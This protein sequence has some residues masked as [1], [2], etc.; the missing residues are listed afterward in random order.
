MGFVLVS[1]A[2][3]F[4]YAQDRTISG[5][6]TSTEDGTTLPGVNVVLK[7]TS[8][9][10]VTDVDGNYKLT[11][12]SEGGVLVFS[13][14]G[15]TSQEVEI[16]ARSVIDV[17]MAA[18]VTQLSEVV[19]TALGLEKNPREL[20]YAVS[21]VKAEDLVVAR[22][23]NVISALNGKVTGVTIQ[24]SSGNLG[25]S[26]NII[27]RGITSLSGNNAPL[28]VVDG[29]PINNQQT[30]TGS[31]ITG[32]RDFSNGAVAL[33]PDDIESINV[34]K[35]GAAS[36][37]YGSRAAAGV[38]V[39]TTKKG[40]AGQGGKPQ[41][42]VNSSVRFDRLFTR[43]DYQFEYSGGSFAKYDSSLRTTAFGERII[44]QEVS[45]AI[46]GERVPLQAY[47]DNVDE[48]FDT[49]VSLINNV[50][51]SDANE[52]MDY[53]LSLTSLNQ[54]GILPNATLDRLTGNFGAGV[55]HANWIKSR[56][57]IQYTRETSQGTGVAGANDPNIFNL[58]NFVPTTDFRDFRP[59]IDE[60]G[61]QINTV[62]N[63]DN[64]PF[65]V[66]FENRNEREQD[67]FIGSYELTITPIENLNVVSRIGLDNW[68]DE[69]FITNRVGT[70]G[71]ATGTF[72]V[73]IL[74]RRQL[75]IDIVST[76]YKKINEDISLNFLGAFNY[77]RRVFERDRLFAESLS[78]PELFS[79]GNALT[80]TPT[81]DE[82]ERKLFGVA[83][84]A[85]ISYKDWAT[86]TLTARNDWSSTLPLENNSY[87]YP[88]ASLAFVFTDAFQISNN[89]LSFGKFRASYAQVGNDT[90]PYQLD[91]RFF[92][93]T[94]ATGQYSLN[95]NFPFDGRLGFAKTNT[96]P[97][98]TLIPEDQITYEF[99][100]ELQFFN[101]RLGLDVTYFFSENTNQILN[102]SIPPSTGF[103]Q[104]TVNVGSID[105]EGIEISIDA[106]PVEVGNFRWNTIVN[107]SHVESTVTE[108]APGL[109]RFLQ[110]SGFNSVQVVAVPGREFQLFGIP[111][112]RE[113]TTGRIVI[114]EETGLRVPGAAK[115]YG[116][117]MPDFT[118][119]FV[120]NF[121]YKG[122]SLSAT[123]DWRQGGL[124]RSASVEALWDGGLTEETL[125]NRE[126]TFID[127]AGVI[128][129]SDGTVREN[130][131]PV[132]SAEDFWAN[133]SANSVSESTVFDATFVKLREVGFSY[134]LPKSV[135]DKI[136]FSGVQV[137]VEGRNLA[138][139]YSKVPH[140][141]P[142]A[143]L[144]GPGQAGV[145]FGVERASVPSTRSFG[146]N[147][148]LTF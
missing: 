1:F 138:L 18:D 136:P 147:V 105:N 125:R 120:N 100:T 19:V 48:Y 26:S 112:E 3:S 84:Q 41:I 72:D 140:I 113:P 44:G 34:L 143:N 115:N 24:Q 43:P 88:S 39:V 30:A 8:T 15:L 87:F 68:V 77:N 37:L 70:R 108:L 66:Q 137:G 83:G 57:N 50:S 122:F 110:A 76:Y 141:D 111:Y 45:K 42:T 92:P 116:S 33:N 135:I 103:A 12:P 55:K 90:N 31:R 124:L 11:V 27:V 78:I 101:G 74:Q 95:L 123:I 86:L 14:I 52:R 54:E 67:R 107:F 69:R 134:T 56:F 114:D 119:G 71:R 121:T 62:N 13:F 81:R 145:G 17:Q 75:N 89:I 96:I 73:D 46:T 109:D 65:W 93:V 132:R 104:R 35:G 91:F 53:R 97:P 10:T 58:A 61:N 5:K 28:W 127:R 7:G 98:V 29:V 142:E 130:D 118:M 102:V 117:V 51:L 79:P 129:Q 49:G 128:V 63:Q 80:T 126:G 9:G 2:C 82:S 40:K 16:G 23:S 4:V 99:G 131:V 94:Q 38:I 144:F 25:G 64:N 146:F 47:E 6:V 106:T 36:A 148:R 139:L 85:E 59:W 133:L 22:E 20:G 60:S 32:N 21:G